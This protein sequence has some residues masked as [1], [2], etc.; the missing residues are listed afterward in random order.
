MHSV[1]RLQSEV[2]AELQ[3]DFAP[4]GRGKMVRG[5]RGVEGGIPG[6]V[7]RQQFAKLALI[8]RM[9][10]AFYE[11]FGELKLLCYSFIFL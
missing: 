9:D 7:E 2:N 10:N 6:D 11:S 5:S 4:T 8:D 1:M 3:G